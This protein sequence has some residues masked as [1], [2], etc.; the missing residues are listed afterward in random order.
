MR[1]G[2]RMK[3]RRCSREDD[4]IGAGS[5]NFPCGVVASQGSETVRDGLELCEPVDPLS[6]GLTA[7]EDIC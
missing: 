1:I 6:R 7:G 2:R 3:I 5:T 4:T